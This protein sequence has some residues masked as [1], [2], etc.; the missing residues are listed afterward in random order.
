MRPKTSDIA[1]IV[2]VTEKEDSCHPFTKND[3]GG[4]PESKLFCDHHAQLPAVVA[5]F[6]KHCGNPGRDR[7]AFSVHETKV[8]FDVSI[9]SDSTKAIRRAS[10]I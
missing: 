8:A 6:A 7:E 5:D 4:T 2:L 1:D 3:A 9:L 10:R